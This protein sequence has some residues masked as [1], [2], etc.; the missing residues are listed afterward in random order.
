MFRS[1][2]GIPITIK[3]RKWCRL[4]VIEQAVFAPATNLG[5][6]REAWRFFATG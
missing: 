1:Y 3:G 5:E 2:A 6:G 4:L